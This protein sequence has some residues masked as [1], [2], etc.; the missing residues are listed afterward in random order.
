[1]NQFPR[2]IINP[3]IESLKL[4]KISDSEY[5]GNDYKN[6]ISNS[7]LSLIYDKNTKSITPDKFF[8]GFK[9]SFNPSFILGSAVHELILQP[10]FFDL[11][12][13]LGRPS[14]KLGAV[15]DELYS[16]AK[17][18]KPTEEEVIKAATK[19]D[20]Y[21]GCLTAKKL[22]ELY[23]K[24]F[25]Y[26]DAR[27]HFE[28]V[29]I[30]DKELIY[31]DSKSRETVLNCV[32]A[33][34]NNKYVNKI[35]NPKNEFGENERAILLDIQVEIPELEAKFILRLK[36]KLD[37]Y[38]IDTLE[39][40]ICVNDVKTIGKVV[41]EAYNNITKFSYNRELAMYSWL[42]SLCAKKFYNINNPTIKGNYLFVSTI[43]SYYTKVIP[44]TKKMFA[45]GFNEFKYLLKLVAYHVATDYKDFAYKWI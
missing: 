15:A 10:E 19:I 34:K 41:S 24:C 21:S 44:M 29:Y 39:E 6:F 4:L 14:A 35:L 11:A 9:S 27:K 17:N 45:E 28:S 18:R 20:Y 31:L 16:I 26:W 23:D 2:I 32:K 7:R 36:S 43:P 8:S 30:E 37:N 33:L 40:N 38:T 25:P 3:I 22:D 42:L 13:D 1:M 12:D 5:F